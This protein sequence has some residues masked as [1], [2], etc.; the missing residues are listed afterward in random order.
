M[1]R[2]FVPLSRGLLV[3]ASFTAAARY[4][5]WIEQRLQQIKQSDSTAWKTI[6]WVATL[7]EARARSREEKRPVFLFTHD[8]NLETGRC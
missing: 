2:A 7:T 6:P 8:G 3:R 4:S 1:R 5:K